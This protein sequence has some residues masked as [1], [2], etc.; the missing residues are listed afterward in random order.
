MSFWCRRCMRPRQGGH[1]SRCWLCPQLTHVLLSA[2]QAAQRLWAGH[3]V[4]MQPHAELG[5]YLAPAAEQRPALGLRVLMLHGVQHEVDA[6][7]P[8]PAAAT[9]PGLQC[10]MRAGDSSSPGVDVASGAGWPA[11]HASC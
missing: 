7:L 9:E 3:G 4:S 6:A 1:A 8:D 11:S 5:S 10:W 2:M